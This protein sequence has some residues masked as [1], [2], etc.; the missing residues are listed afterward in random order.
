MKGW[1]SQEILFKKGT[2]QLKQSA[3]QVPEQWAWATYLF[4]KCK[5]HAEEIDVIKSNA[6]MARFAAAALSPESLKK[7]KKDMSDDYHNEFLRS[8]G[9]I[10]EPLEPWADA[11]GKL[12]ATAEAANLE[13]DAPE[14]NSSTPA[15]KRPRK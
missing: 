9:A 8:L 14:V 11:C 7:L 6:F 3:E 15:K 13:L 10:K 2:D 1:V 4:D 12:K 5:M